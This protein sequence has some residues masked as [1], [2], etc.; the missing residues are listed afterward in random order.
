MIPMWYLEHCC[1]WKIVLHLNRLNDGQ[2]ARNKN[3]MHLILFF[4]CQYAS[5]AASMFPL[6]GRSRL[7]LA[8]FLLITRSITSQINFSL[9][10]AK[11]SQ[12]ESKLITRFMYLGKLLHYFFWPQRGEWCV[13][14]CVMLCTFHQCFLS[15]KI[16]HL[17]PLDE[18]M[19]FNFK[20]VKCKQ[21]F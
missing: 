9:L 16:R 10:V 15:S 7:S 6:L 17:H 18:L 4:H 13:C 14:V 11:N 19:H 12:N 2:H 21:F 5:A 8:S 1:L 3:L 20:N